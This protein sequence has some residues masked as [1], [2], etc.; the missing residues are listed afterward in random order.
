[1]STI[2]RRLVGL[3]LA[4]LLVAGVAGLLRAGIYGWTIFVLCPVVLGGLGA[5]AFRPG[6]KTAAGFLLLVFG[7]EGLLCILMS[8][9]LGAL[10]GWLVWQARTS[11]SAARGA[12]MLLLL[13]SAM[14]VE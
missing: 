14:E 8:L 5:W 12:T 7:L 9:P 11:R 10:G 4:V 3:L 13:P 6:T 1:M 2:A